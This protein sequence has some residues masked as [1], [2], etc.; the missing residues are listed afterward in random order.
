VLPQRDSYSLRR[1]ASSRPFFS[2]IEFVLNPMRQQPLPLH[3]PAV[4]AHEYASLKLIRVLCE[5]NDGR[6][7]RITALKESRRHQYVEVLPY[8]GTAKFLKRCHR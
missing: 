7:V 2:I 5:A 8:V 4:A 3:S 6:H 1:F